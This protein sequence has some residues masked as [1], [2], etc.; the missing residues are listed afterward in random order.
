MTEQLERP[1]LYFLGELIDIPPFQ[2]HGPFT[3]TNSVV[4][5]INGSTFSA[6]ELTT[7]ILKQLP[8]VTAVGDTTGGG[9]GASNSSGAA[10]GDY[11]LPSR[12]LINIPT[13]YFERYNG[14]LIEWHGVPP[15]IRIVQTE[16]DILAGIDKQL[17]YAIE[18]LR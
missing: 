15:D 13:G 10:I 4:I 14:Q 11:K 2:P 3:Y 12:K 6:G 1:N 9:G 8:N 17:E 5:L 18:I 16:A 7:E